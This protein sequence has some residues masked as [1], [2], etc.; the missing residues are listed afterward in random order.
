MSAT[1]KTTGKTTGKNTR[2][3]R[4]ERLTVLE[5]LRI[6]LRALRTSYKARGRASSLVSVL[7]FALALLPM[8]VSL[9]LRQ[10]TDAVQALFDGRAELDSALLLF[11]A[12]TALSLCQL[13]YNGVRSYYAQADAQRIQQYIK[14]SVLRC[15]CSVKLKYIENYDDF[16]EKIAFVDSYAG[17]EV[18]HSMQEVT[19]WLQNLVTFVALSV[20]LASINVWIIPVIIITCAPGIVLA[21]RQEREK[22]DQNKKMNR[23]R[24]FIQH[25][26]QDCTRFQSLQELRFQRIFPYIKG[27]W[28]QTVGE[29]IES[30]SA[31]KRKH[32]L[33][34]G[35][36][37]LLRGSV[38]VF[39]LIIVAYEIYQ[40]PAVGI[41]AFMLV[42]SVAGQMQELTARLFFGI[43]QFAS[44]VRYMKDFF[45]LEN[46]EYE[47]KPVDAPPLPNADIRFDDVSFAY[48][49]TSSF[50]LKDIDVTI[51]QGE[52]IAVV[53]K[54]GSGKST[55]VNLLCA[56][57]N[58]QE[59]TVTV[60]G[61]PTTKNTSQ[62]RQNISVVF[63]DFGK[64]EDTVRFNITVSDR[65]RWLDD[66]ALLALCKRTGVSDFIQESPRGLDE[67][68][69]SFS[70]YGNTFSGGQ[71][72]KL[73]LSRA[74]YRSDTAIMILDEPTAAL[75]PLAEANLYR[76]FAGLTEDKTT[77]LISHRLGV[78]SIVD[79]V[80][81]FDEGRIVEDGSH[82][83]L[84]ERGGLYS[85]MYKAQAQWY[86]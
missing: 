82:D 57:Y 37:D 25:Y 26:Y 65:R 1:G 32:T 63:Q 8:L 61:M 42:I 70:Q 14:E 60:G 3:A 85:E 69:G 67:V 7:G 36:A 31:L 6:V 13:F 77:I 2:S 83:E 38:Y 47:Q 80:L 46:L 66:D 33:A 54:N 48:P 19:A 59:G 4:V 27:K 53:G 81:V 62:I 43:T 76:N 40:S 18:A 34:N 64:Y 72:Q 41:G 10:F 45:D 55:F 29:Y 22:Y 58:P 51:C 23:T 20:V 71:W 73:A 16:S 11:M 12:L 35:V 50:A 9:T 86:H 56:L 75:D 30:D 68:I 21:H 15:V 84:M 49:N 74:I 28:R 44:N 52:K 17:R 79:R 5:L 24:A 78:T 39:I